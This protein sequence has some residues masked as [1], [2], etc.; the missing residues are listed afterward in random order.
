MKKDL[1]TAMG[2]RMRLLRK[3]RGLS[4]EN[5]ADSL[6]LS[7]KHISYS[8]TGK[9]S[10]SLE[11][12]CEY[13]KLFNCS[14]DYLVLGETQNPALSELPPEICNIL[15]SGTIEEKDRLRRYLQMYLEING[16]S[17]D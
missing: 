10:L 8:E 5:I 3:S 12:L 16:T 6:S 14:L 2:K 13:C 7:Q 11:N 4:Q 17:K 15:Y 1:L 9:A